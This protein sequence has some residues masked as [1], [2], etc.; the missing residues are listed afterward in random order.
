MAYKKFNIKEIRKNFTND[1]RTASIIITNIFIIISNH[2]IEC[3]IF[4]TIV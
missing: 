4:A 1:R 2:T 3:P